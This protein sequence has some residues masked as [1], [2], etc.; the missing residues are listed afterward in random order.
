MTAEKLSIVEEAIERG[1][2][3]PRSL[4]LVRISRNALYNWRMDAQAFPDDR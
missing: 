4:A 1:M 2:T 3:I